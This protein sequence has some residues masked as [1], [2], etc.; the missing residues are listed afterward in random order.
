VI[1]AMARMYVSGQGAHHVA[2]Q[3][4]AANRDT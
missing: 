1:G 4:H 3:A 2:E